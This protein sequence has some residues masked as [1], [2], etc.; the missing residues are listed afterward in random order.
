MS[1]K[2]LGLADSGFGKTYATKG[3]NPQ[4]TGIISVLGKFPPFAGSVDV[5]KPVD[6]TNNTG[7]FISLRGINPKDVYNKFIGALNYFN[8]KRPDIKNI[9]GDDI[10]AI[11]GNEFMAR[12]DEKGYDKFTDIGQKMFKILTK[13]DELRDEVIVYLLSHLEYMTMPNG[14]KKAKMKTIGAMLDQYATPEGTFDVVL[15]GEATRTP[16]KKILREFKTND[17][18]DSTAKS[19]EGMFK[20][21]KIPNDLGIVEEAIRKFYRI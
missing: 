2:V 19:P 21:D 10:Q 7:N 18:V 8:D 16:D 20:T 1:F 5:Y 6:F 15:V 12:A 17:A 14:T 9:V 13:S 4:T 3:L 11:M